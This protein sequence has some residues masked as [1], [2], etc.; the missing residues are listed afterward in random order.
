M[1]GAY[2]LEFTERVLE[3]GVPSFGIFNLLLDFFDILETRDKGIGTLV[4]AYQTKLFRYAGVEPQLD[5]CI[6]CGEKKAGC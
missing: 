6:V 3:E 4:L 1:N 5:R 2:V